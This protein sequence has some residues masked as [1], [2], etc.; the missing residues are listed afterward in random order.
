[1]SSFFFF[2]GWS[3][4]SVNGPVLAT[5]DRGQGVGWFMVSQV[6]GVTQART[7]EHVTFRSGKA[8]GGFCDSA[9][10]HATHHH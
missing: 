5:H 7:W 3:I 6:P 9:R 4:L 8:Q 2:L 10:A 1:M